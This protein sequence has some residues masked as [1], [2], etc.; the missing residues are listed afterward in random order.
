M[1]FFTYIFFFCGGTTMSKDKSRG[2][3]LFKHFVEFLKIWGQEN[4]GEN[5]ELN[6]PAIFAFTNSFSILDFRDDLEEVIFSESDEEFRDKCYTWIENQILNDYPIWRLFHI[7]GWLKDKLEQGFIQSELQKDRNLFETRKCYTC[8][9]F[10]DD[11]HFIGED[12]YSHSYK[13]ERHL[14]IKG[15]SLMHLMSCGK[16][17]ELVSAISDKFMHR[18]DI[19]FTYGQFS[20]N[21]RSQF[22]SR[23]K[24]YPYEHSECPY[25]EKNDITF[26]EFIDKYGEVLDQ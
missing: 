5:V 11:V 9:Y 17:N 19:D 23:W 1:L 12:K 10:S 24:L 7:N 26:E 2:I 18:S 22:G 13:T 8:K 21:W 25:Y 15:T 6:W 14:Y 20:M 16:R 4:Y 3:I